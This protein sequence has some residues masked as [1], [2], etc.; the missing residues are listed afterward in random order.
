M[1][2]RKIEE[3][4]KLSGKMGNCLIEDA[5]RTKNSFHYS[6][7]AIVCLAWIGADAE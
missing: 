5:Q 6:A 4:S 1:L 3:F 2:I 7:L